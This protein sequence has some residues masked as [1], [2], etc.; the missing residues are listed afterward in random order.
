M[1]LARVLQVIS[2]DPNMNSSEDLLGSLE[3]LS[4]D[5][6]DKLSAEAVAAIKRVGVYLSRHL[7]FHEAVGSHEYQ[8]PRLTPFEQK[9]AG[10]VIH[11]IFMAGS[12][13]WDIETVTEPETAQELV[14]DEIHLLV[15]QVI[16]SCMI[17]FPLDQPNYLMQHAYPVTILSE[18][19]RTS[20]YWVIMIVESTKFLIRLFG[21]NTHAMP[22]LLQDQLDPKKLRPFSEPLTLQEETALLRYLDTRCRRYLIFVLNMLH[23]VRDC[24]RHRGSKEEQIIAFCTAPWLALVFFATRKIVDEM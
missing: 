14:L 22:L 12:V 15:M 17:R 23:N 20:S 11:H 16:G 24:Q 7:T 10:Y 2:Q 18:V 3:S 19:T 21:S 8:D 4:P 6:F 13:S 9:L 1:Y 5:T